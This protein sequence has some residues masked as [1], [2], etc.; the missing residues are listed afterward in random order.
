MTRKLTRDELLLSMARRAERM[1]RDAVQLGKEMA[2]IDEF[3]Y[4]AENIIRDIQRVGGDIHRIVA[5]EP[6]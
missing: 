6:I 5:G 1:E 4:T 2:R 3:C